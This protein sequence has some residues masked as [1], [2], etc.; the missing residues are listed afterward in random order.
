MR[1]RLRR[2]SARTFGPLPSTVYRSGQGHFGRQGA[3]LTVQ[4]RCPAQIPVLTQNFLIR[5]ALLLCC[6]IAKRFHCFLARFKISAMGEWNIIRRKS[7]VKCDVK[8]FRY[9]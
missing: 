7:T 2:R 3:H 9:F 5:S 6:C 1:K 4:G 8:R